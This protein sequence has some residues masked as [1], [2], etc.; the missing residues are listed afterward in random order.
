MTITADNESTP[1][2][3]ALT[4]HRAYSDWLAEH[5][6]VP[7]E[8]SRALTRHAAGAEV[9]R[10][11]VGKGMTVSAMLAAWS[12]SYAAGH[13]QVPV[14][15]HHVG[16]TAE[17]RSVDN[18]L[19]R[20]L[21]WIRGRCELR[22][23]VPVDPDA[24]VEILPNWLA[25]L[26]S[27]GRCVLVLDRLDALEDE[28][29]EQAMSW[30][31]D[32]LPRPLRL[33]VGLAPGSAVEMLRSRGWTVEEY[34]S[35]AP[36]AELP[37]ETA[38]NPSAVTA[39]AALASCRRGL[40]AEQLA[41]VAAAP[42]MDELPALLRNQVYMANG[43]LTLA[44][45]DIRDAVRRRYLAD[46]ADRQALQARVAAHLRDPL[47]ADALDQCPWMLVRAGD[48]TGLAGL[49][50][51]RP[52]LDDLLR[53]GW[54]DDLIA[55]WRLWGSGAEIMAFYTAQARAWESEAADAALAW[56]LLRLV[57]ALQ[58]LPEPGDPAALLALAEKYAD[59]EDSLCRAAL[60]AVRGAW[61]AEQEEYGAARPL[62]RRSLET[63]TAELGPDHPDTR[64]TRHRLAMLLESTDDLAAATELY[65][66]TLAHRERALGRMHRELIP[67]L[68]NLAA[69]VKAANDLDA[70]RPLYQRAL[71]IA[72]RH[73]GNAHPTTA[74]CVD[75]LAGLLYAGHDFEQA[76][77]LYQRALGIAEA[78]FGPNHSATAASAHNLA[79]VMDAR[80]QYQAAEML[81]R[82]ALEIRREVAGD[83]HMDTASS[84]HNL[85]GVLDAMGRYD[86]AE[87]MYRRAVE[88]WEKVVGRDHPATATS[89]NNLA[90]LLREKGEYGEAEA[91][92][93]R[94]LQTW[95]E[96]LGE[97]H[98][99][100]V[101]TRS[102]LA[103][104]HADAGRP[105]EAERLLR[106]AAEETASVMGWDS[107]QHINTVV[108][109]AALLRDTGRRDEARSALK[110]T[111][112]HAEGRVSM[113]SPRIQKLRRHLE[114]LDR[115]PDSLH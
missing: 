37:R 71:Q 54:Q 8:V 31:P 19:H 102:E 81:F 105:D 72:E 45:P 61:L 52:V 21:D 103:I 112:R 83:D 78:V 111:L 59:T 79:T 89:V 22:E 5:A 56:L 69:V 41:T 29:A 75:N 48:W 57:T 108:R 13:E 80:E 64:A 28:G 17:S 77:D 97:R 43:R 114:V 27:R 6:S 98:P 46:G 110:E 55:T 39:L 11:L 74:A 68:V 70:A 7:R 101:M 42:D 3:R 25:R 104:L 107:M 65:R 85:A 26:A 88:T 94:N 66:E 44:G 93:R 14:F 33:L 76:E 50:G 106:Q 34:P 58:E 36:P 90:D 9:P 16:C 38:E 20:L 15:V 24:R 2:Q 30:L 53:S 82:R 92:Y 95:T 1:L 63:R 62:L 100:T 115:D 73:Y 87:P 86:E 96:L 49:L 12:R 109:M 67:H 4:D 60:D 23:P 91:L 47:S 32:W 84:L 10:V 51:D 113:L 18:L 99:H 35:D 40:S